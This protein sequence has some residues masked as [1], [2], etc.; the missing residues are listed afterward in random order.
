MNDDQHELWHTQHGGQSRQAGDGASCAPG[1]SGYQAAIQDLEDR[2]RRIEK[3]HQEWESALDVVEDP[4]FLHDRNL[5]ILRCNSAY[6]RCAGLPFNLIVGRLYY[7]V[8]PKTDF[9]V[10][11]CRWAIEAAMSNE[12]VSE[13]V[14]VGD[15]IYN[16]REFSIRNGEGVYLYS[17]HI[18]ENVTERK[19]A[20]AHLRLFRALLDNSS[21]AIEVIDPTSLRLLDVNET[22]CH[23]LGYSREELLS[24][25]VTD[26]DHAFDAKMNTMV[27]EQLLQ[28]G[29]ARFESMHR[30]KD[31]S[32]FP[33]EVSATVIELDKS[34]GVSIARDITER[35]K[36]Q[37]ELLRL[38]RVLK[39]MSEVNQNLLRASD[40]SE[41]MD[42]VCKVLAVNTG[43]SLAWIGLGRHDEDRTIE[44]VAKAGDCED[45]V[46]RLHLSWGAG[47]AGLGPS[48]SAV[49][50][51]RTQIVQDIKNDPRFD[52]WREAVEK[53]GHASSIALPLKAG[54]TAFG[55]LSIYSREASAFSANEVALLEEVAE[56]L[57]FG[58]VNLRTRMERDQAVR[59]RQA[60]ME[61]LRANLEDALQAI[62]TTVEMRDPYTAGH[63]RRV[64]H[65]SKL[66]AT[67]LGLSDEEAHGIYLAAIVHDIGKISVPAEI[68]NKP[69][70]LSEMEMAIVKKHVSDTYTILKGIQFPWPI[71]DMA[72]QHHERLDG[73]GYPLGLKG[74]D[75]LFGSRIM[76]VADVVEAMS[77]H[78]PY[79]PGRGIQAALEEIRKG[80][81]TIYDASV[82]DA[83]CK[84]FDAGLATF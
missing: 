76:A 41:L 15:T 65:L 71:A 37:A 68:L 67:K 13:E 22:E 29:S 73:T 10:Q 61:R 70:R 42:N 83:C 46:D 59:E 20:E 19:K 43:Y 64:A 72:R 30:R 63:Q 25:A 80:R 36:A 75:I 60:Y 31:G 56:D 7:E 66:L 53:Y 17:V 1:A 62:A 47:P 39:T 50:T 82:V 81:A 18:L 14:L 84:L 34:Y 27:Q 4:I 69:T 3:A 12:C 74:D 8:F 55:V 40:E 77:S 33:V 9:L 38:N 11:R 23:S 21:D 28:S 48:G 79:R 54:G 5:R 44:A 2:V 6:Q 24:M 45:Y 58:I 57:A 32:T 26:I 16:S 52:P 78:R 51:G 49:R 35:K